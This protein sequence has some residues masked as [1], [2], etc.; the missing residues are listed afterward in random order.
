M[1][2][3]YPFF[4][5][6]D[7]RT[8]A[9]IGEEAADS[10]LNG[11]YQ[12][13]Y[14]ILSQKRLY[15]KNE[16][17]N[18]IADGRSVRFQGREKARRPWMVLISALL[19]LSILITLF[20]DGSALGLLTF[21]TQRAAGEA[22]KLSAAAEEVNDLW[23]EMKLPCE[24]DDR[25][26]TEGLSLEE[27]IGRWWYVDLY[28]D[29]P[30]YYN[31][32][33]RIYYQEEEMPPTL[34][35]YLGR[36]S[37]KELKQIYDDCELGTLPAD[38]SAAK[39]TLLNA[40]ALLTVNSA[41]PPADLTRDQQVT[42]LALLARKFRQE[43]L[44]P[45]FSEF[46]YIGDISFS[47]E[48]RS[49]FTQFC[50]LIRQMGGV[51]EYDAA[52]Y[53]VKDDHPYPYATYSSIDYRD[54][55]LYGD[56]PGDRELAQKYPSDNITE[57]IEFLVQFRLFCAFGD[58][59]LNALTPEQKALAQRVR[60]DNQTYYALSANNND[61]VRMLRE[62]ISWYYPGAADLR[63][64][65]SMIAWVYF[66]SATADATADD[67]LTMVELTTK[68]RMSPEDAI[69]EAGLDNSKEESSASPFSDEALEEVAKYSQ[70][71][72]ENLLLP[73]AQIEEGKLELFMSYVDKTERFLALRDS[74]GYEAQQLARWSSPDGLRRAAL[75]S[76]LCAWAALIG[77]VALLA[78]FVLNLGKLAGLAGI[79]AGA[80][81]VLC[82]ILG[83][84]QRVN[85][86]YR[87]PYMITK[88]LPAA[89]GLVVVVLCVITLLLLI[90]KSAVPTFRLITSTGA[91]TFREKDYSKEEREAFAA[92]VSRGEGGN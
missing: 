89:V 38:R 6:V 14:A 17:G 44:K 78:L 53:Y 58:Y 33:D 26:W 56:L 25:Y 40:E 43:D 45:F 29:N 80:V 84:P 18:F 85:L 60:L 82:G 73:L 10:D 15:C 47:S 87:L 66:D 54:Y 48:S 49:Y 31:E 8:Q 11:E 13:P 91:F 72:R 74:T 69:Q 46:S 32:W 35:D 21:Q 90:K 59:D 62:F 1:R 71:D 76:T 50:D 27:D 83:A 70:A 81:C 28:N 37:A 86:N 16:Q 41:E 63:S 79:A 36:Y 67:F 9:V 57:R 12:K 61:T 55:L 68:L 52:T 77:G 19:L 88:W 34:A 65:T 20:V 5:D 51:S 22:A 42:Q 23:W 24:W 92:A 3:Q 7:E 4:R 30:W 75:F 39:A 2:E 64:T